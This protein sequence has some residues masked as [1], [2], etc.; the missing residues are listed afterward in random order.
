MSESNN[1][2]QFKKQMKYACFHYMCSV[3][4]QVRVDTHSVTQ[5]P[6]DSITNLHLSTVHLY[7]CENIMGNDKKQDKRNLL[8]LFIRHALLKISQIV[9]PLPSLKTTYTL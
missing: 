9:K 7:T 2:D 5:F 1:K 4:V 8:L 3:E 6:I